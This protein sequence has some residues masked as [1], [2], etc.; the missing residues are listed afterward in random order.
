M[1]DIT[2]LHLSDLHIDNTSKTYSKLLKNLISDIKTE[3]GFIKDK[4]LIVVVTGDILHKATQFSKD[5]TAFNNAEKFFKDLYAVLK[6]KVANIYLVPGNHDKFRADHNKFL[7]PAYRV[8]SDQTLLSE[9]AVPEFDENFYKNFWKFHLDTYAQESGSGFLELSKNI[10]KTFGLSD[11]EIEL[12]SYANETFG[13]DVID[14][15]NKKYCFILLNTA[16][17]CIDENDTRNI[18]LGQFQIDKLRNQHQ[19]LIN[20][21]CDSESPCLTIVLGHHPLNSLKGTEEDKI[22][23]EMIS[24]DGFDANVY[25]SGHTHDRTVTNWV[26][27]R[28]SL[29][30]FVT[31][32]GWPENPGGVHVS[33]NHTYSF[34]T[35]NLNANSVDVFVRSTN[36][37]GSFSPD[38]S[39][40]TNNHDANRK[41]LVFP[42]RAEYAQTYIPLS[43][44]DNDSP[45]A[46]YISNDFIRYIKDYF[47]NVE[48]LRTIFGIAL[49]QDKIDFYDNIYVNNDEYEQNENDDEALYQ[50]LFASTLEQSHDIPKSVE[51]TLRKNRKMLFSMLLGFLQKICEKM[52]Q[53]FIEDICDENDIVRFHF[54][55]LSDKNIFQ[56][57][58]LCISFPKES[59]FENNDVTEIKYGQLIEKAFT[60]QNSLIYSINKKFVQK[61]LNEKWTNFI[62]I[63]PLFPRNTYTRRYTTKIKNF[64]FITFGVTTNNDKYDELLYCMDYFSFKDTISDI[65]EQYLEVFNINLGEF[66]DWLKVEL[67]RGEDNE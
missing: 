16:W 59:D 50:Y 39:I 23:S 41:K 52:Q 17:S 65:V 38:F 7:I 37:G 54:R 56:Y 60:S 45:K 42:I 67:E 12:K 66:C 47:K 15:N 36:D 1:N 53:V 21:T 27:N 10:Y 51:N 3:L 26:N 55:Y 61:D 35:F 32:I 9:S 57:L 2:I 49:E 28:H 62:T 33:N 8:L 30:T 20:Q 13:V 64:P 19:E 14:I 48:K 58:R 46:Y 4:S 5:S 22:F 18:V 31:G 24:F 25:L 43:V 6:G 44:G 11:D 63:V 29:N 34:Y 40:Y